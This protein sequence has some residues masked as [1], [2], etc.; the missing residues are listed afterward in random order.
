MS[1]G[2]LNYFSSVFSDNFPKIYFN[3]RQENSK[4]PV[5]SVFIGDVAIVLRRLPRVKLNNF[6]ILGIF[7][8]LARNFEF[9]KTPCE[10]FMAAYD[11]C[12]A[13]LTPSHTHQGRHS[14][15]RAI[16]VCEAL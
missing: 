2:N 13:H 9:T 5:K 10:S 4:H 15:S 6:A 8:R 1:H 7:V 11:C 12:L 16:I 14:T 3:I